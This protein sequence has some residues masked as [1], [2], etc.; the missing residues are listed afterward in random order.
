MYLLRYL[1]VGSYC[2]ANIVFFIIFILGVPAKKQSKG[3]E[4]EDLRQ[5]CRT[6]SHLQ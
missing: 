5:A 4:K 2:I 6:L 3:F 1:V